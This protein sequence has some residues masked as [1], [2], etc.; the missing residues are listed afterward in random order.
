MRR[1]TVAVLAMVTV[2][3]AVSQNSLTEYQARVLAHV[4]YTRPENSIGFAGWLILPNILNTDPFRTNSMAGVIVRGEQR[5]METMAGLRIDSKGKTETTIDI[6]VLDQSVPWLDIFAEVEYSFTSR[7]WYFSPIITTTLASQPIGIKAGGEFD[8]FL[9]PQ[10]TT[11][12]Y[13][14]RISLHFPV[15]ESVVQN[16]MFATAFR[17]QVNG[18]PVIRQYLLL[19]F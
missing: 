14:P 2:N 4:Q 1:G 11:V 13:G 3:T 7:Q 17:F 6:R 9:H 10:H 18:E 19:N 8:L 12:Y 5:W 16:V 15:A